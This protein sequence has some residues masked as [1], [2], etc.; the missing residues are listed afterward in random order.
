MNARIPS[1]FRP[2]HDLRVILVGRTGLEGTLRKDEGV[3]LLRASNGLE[4]IGELSNPIDED[5]P[6]RSVVVLGSEALEREDVDSL[7]GSLRRIDESVRIVGVDPISGSSARPVRFSEYDLDGWLA[8]DAQPH[9]F[10]TL[11]MRNG[12]PGAYG[13]ERTAP[14]LHGELESES[15]P[16]S[17][18]E[19]AIAEE[20]TD[21]GF[22]FEARDAISPEAAPEPAP[23]VSLSP[24]AALP[25]VAPGAHT[26]T[27]AP[28]SVTHQSPARSGGGTSSH[29]R[30]DAWTPAPGDRTA[31]GAAPGAPRMTTWTALETSEDLAILRTLLSGGDVLPACMTRLRRRLA[32]NSVEF[33]PAQSADGGTPPLHGPEE[34]LSEVKHRGRL[35]G[36]L[37]G[38]AAL[39]NDFIVLAEWLS[40]CLALQ[41]QHAQLRMAAYTDPLTGAWNRR[42]FDGFLGTSIEQ[43]RARRNSLTLLIFDVDNFKSYNDRFGH[44]AGDVILRETVRLLRSVIRPTDRVCRIGGDEFA[45]VFYEPEGPRDPGSRHPASIVQVVERFQEQILSHRFPMLGT[46]ATGS[47]TISGG[48]ATFPWDGLDV[49]SL[50]RRADGLVLESKRQGKNQICIGG[51]IHRAAEAFEQDGGSWSET[52]L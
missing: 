33:H 8:S 1:Q 28:P 52:P 47:L 35:F 7:I 38:P 3:E 12:V 31:P 46:Q 50:M 4:A 25:T 21:D 17:D 29:A 51:G 40:Q 48:L 19:P 37:C 2:V 39:R 41:E 10:R 9:A 30:A 24:G 42:Y 44:E 14:E 34:S 32:P 45:V 26:P 43:A 15:T 5:S 36:W 23:P 27:E 13:H 6:E 22:H 49:T 18:D 20:R 11:F 16:E